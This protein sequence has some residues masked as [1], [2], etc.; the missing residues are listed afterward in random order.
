MQI[1]AGYYYDNEIDGVL[2][3]DSPTA[4]L[5]EGLLMYAKNLKLFRGITNTVK[6]NIKNQDQKP[7]GLQ[8]LSL[9]FRLFTPNGKSI[10]WE[11]PMHCNLAYTGQATVTIPQTI[12]AVMP[13][14]LYR[15][16]VVTTD[17]N[18]IQLP[19]FVNDA[20]NALG[21]AEINDNIVPSFVESHVCEFT[22]P[23]DGL[24]NT[25]AVQ[26]TEKMIASCACATTQWWGDY[27]GNLIIQTAL[28]PI[29]TSATIWYDAASQTLDGTQPNGTITVSGKFTYVRAQFLS[30][31][32][33][34][35]PA[36]VI[37]TATGNFSQ[38]LIRV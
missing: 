19:V 29:A 6:L 10:V 12:L 30:S 36:G 32:Q 33:A 13:N 37:T 31:N 3:S 21:I 34:V 18:G 15:Y 23:V 17:G 5:R 20:Y 7:Y 26:V 25:D 11:G 1:L 14:G 38:I 16:S 24:I 27:V 4:T 8:Q 22:T 9:W 28:D 2:I 35:M